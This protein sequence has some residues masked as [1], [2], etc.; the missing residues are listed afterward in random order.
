MAKRVRKLTPDV[1]LVRVLV[2]VRAA[3]T[4]AKGAAWNLLHRI[5]SMAATANGTKSKRRKKATKKK[6]KTK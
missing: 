3:K 1:A 4:V 2:S 5:E 6:K